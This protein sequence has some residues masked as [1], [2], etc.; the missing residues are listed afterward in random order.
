MLQLEHSAILFTCIKLSLIF[1]LR[2]LFYLFLS[3][4]LQR[5]YCIF[6][7]FYSAL[8]LQLC[9]IT[10]G[11]LPTESSSIDSIPEHEDFAAYQRELSRALVAKGDTSTGSGEVLLNPLYTNGFFLRV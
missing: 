10:N 4:R 1:S 8:G 5:F 7:S 2:S 11:T 3:V 6:L 9:P